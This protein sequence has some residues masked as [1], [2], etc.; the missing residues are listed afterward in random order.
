MKFS[1]RLPDPSLP[2]PIVK[3]GVYLLCQREKCVNKAYLD[4]PSRTPTI[5]WG[6][7]EGVYLGMEWTDAECD[8]NLLES[9]IKYTTAVRAMCKVQPSEK[10]LAALVVCAYNIGLG[11]MKGSSMMRLHNQGKFIEAARAF[12]LWNKAT[13]KQTGKL[14]VVDELVSRR[15]AEAALYT[16]NDTGTP[17][18]PSP[19]EV[20]PERP[21]AASPTVVTASTAIGIGGITTV[22]STLKDAGEQLT[23]FAKTFAADLGLT[24]PQMLGALLVVIGVIVLYRRWGQHRDGVA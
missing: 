21:I 5:G 3:Q 13:D 14:I 6:E 4:W 10:Q 16:E 17:Q 18:Y 23:G 15:L 22:L 19:Q 1:D 20:A 11:A 7:T 2:W 8:Q 9:L 12:S 24:T